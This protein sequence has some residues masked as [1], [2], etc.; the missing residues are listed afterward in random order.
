LFFDAPPR[1]LALPAFLT[2][3]KLRGAELDPKTRLLYDACNYYINGE[4]ALLSAALR[5]DLQSL[6][7]TR[8]VDRQIS[9][10]LS[11]DSPVTHLLYEWYCAGWMRFS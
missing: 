4:N 9:V 3:L 5:R 7:N 1:P 6:A 8:I 11:H 10:T 2:R